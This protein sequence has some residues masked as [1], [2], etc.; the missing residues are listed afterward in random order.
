M[1]NKGYYLRARMTPNT[2]CLNSEGSLGS[3]GGA[4]RVRHHPVLDFGQADRHVHDV[5]VRR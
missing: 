4:R 2:P 1:T 3:T 5:H